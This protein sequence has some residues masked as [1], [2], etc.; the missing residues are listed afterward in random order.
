M[1]PRP[2][3]HP[4]RRSLLRALVLSLAATGALAATACSGTRQDGE[5]GAQAT[6]EATTIVVENRSYLDHTVY[7]VRSGQRIRLG[8]ATG[9]AS[10]RFTIPRNLVHGTVRLSFLVDPIGGQR[11]PV[12]NEIT[13]TEG[14]EMRLVIPPA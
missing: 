7:V 11:A 9:N 14:D 3:T 12:S 4:T 13:V 8:T 10:Q 6:P 1:R 5:A 2:R